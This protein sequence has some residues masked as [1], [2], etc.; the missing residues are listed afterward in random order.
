MDVYF[1]YYKTL[2]FFLKRDSDFHQND[3]DWQKVRHPEF[4]SGSF[5]KS[6]LAFARMTCLDRDSDLPTHAQH[7]K[8]DEG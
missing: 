8:N 6:I 3:E 1:I 4:S 7:V 2:C 5:G